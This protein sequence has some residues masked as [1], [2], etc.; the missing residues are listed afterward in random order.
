MLGDGYHKKA[1]CQ[2]FGLQNIYAHGGTALFVKVHTNQRQLR[3]GVMCRPLQ[4]LLLLI[5]SLED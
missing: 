1:S 5:L 4:E 2:H 3:Q